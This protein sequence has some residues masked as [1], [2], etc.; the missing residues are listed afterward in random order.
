MYVTL[1]RTYHEVAVGQ[2]DNVSLG[3]TEV[4]C[5]VLAVK[6]ATLS[7]QNNEFSWS[8]MQDDKSMF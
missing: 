3:S 5:N 4:H 6:I 2:D 8:E 1:K 7:W